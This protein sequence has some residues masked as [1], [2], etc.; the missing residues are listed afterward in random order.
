V[1]NE[2][3]WVG[4]GR[5]NMI[6]FLAMTWCCDW[7]LRWLGTWGFLEESCTVSFCLPRVKVLSLKVY[8]NACHYGVNT[9]DTSTRS[10]R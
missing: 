6:W 7:I 10:P 5:C 2:C 1:H 9:L 4:F 8:S 3:K